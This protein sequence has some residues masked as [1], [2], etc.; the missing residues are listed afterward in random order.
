MEC[1]GSVAGISH[2]NA[3]ISRLV[4]EVN[5]AGLCSRDS[6]TPFIQRLFQE[7]SCIKLC[8]KRFL[9]LFEHVRPTLQFIVV[10][11]EYE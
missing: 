3:I 1:H 9:W 10:N 8:S 7:R 5:P 2:L 4:T 6:S 11:K